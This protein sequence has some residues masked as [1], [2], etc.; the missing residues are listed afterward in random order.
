M[1]IIIIGFGVCLSLS[2]ILRLLYPSLVPPAHMPSDL[3][4]R[5]WLRTPLQQCEP[6]VYLP[7][8]TLK[9]VWGCGTLRS[10]WP[11]V[12]W[13]PPWPV[14]MTG[15]HFFPLVWWGPVLS[16][17]V[18]LWAYTTNLLWYTVPFREL[19][20]LGGLL[21]L[22]ILPYFVLAGKL[23][24]GVTLHRSLQSQG[25]RNAHRSAGL[26]P[27]FFQVLRLTEMFLGLPVVTV[28]V[29]QHC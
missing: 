14:M 1:N 5:G 13:V 15:R 7:M 6:Q 9:C 2:T 22:E 23:S 3:G 26:K 25:T 17:A 19:L 29:T 12:R 10:L 4:H 20:P 21:G 27:V 16:A 24:G 28:R 11:G 8:A 18:S